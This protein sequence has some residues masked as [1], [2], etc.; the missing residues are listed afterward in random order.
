[1][2]GQEPTTAIREAAGTAVRRLIEF[3]SRQQQTQRT[4]LDWHEGK[5]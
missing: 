3:T 5:S 4:L 1:M 2:R